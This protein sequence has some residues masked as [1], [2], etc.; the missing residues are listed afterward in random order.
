M[1]Y[2]E[3]NKYRELVDEKANK[4]Q[5][6]SICREAAY[7]KC[8]SVVYKTRAKILINIFKTSENLSEIN[9]VFSECNI[10]NMTEKL[11]IEN[12]SSFERRIC[13]QC[14]TTK[15]FRNILIIISLN[16][17][18]KILKEEIHH[19][20]GA[21]SDYMKNTKRVYSQCKNMELLI[22]K[23]LQVTIRIETDWSVLLQTSQWS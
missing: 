23:E 13:L 21:V 17:Q 22:S 18:Q 3:S 10:S 5:F 16:Y 15:T 2:I 1:T 9:T 20:P 12:P 8:A 7:N 14:N 4:N 11:L 6:L 19:L